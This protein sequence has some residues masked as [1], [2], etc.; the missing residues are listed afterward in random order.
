[1]RDRA[2]EVHLITAL[3]ME[4]SYQILALHKVANSSLQ[5][6]IISLV[7][8]MPVFP[9]VLLAERS[10]ASILDLALYHMVTNLLCWVI[11]RHRLL[12]ADSR[13]NCKQLAGNRLVLSSICNKLCLLELEGMDAAVV[14][15]CR[16]TVVSVHRLI[17]IH[18]FQLHAVSSLKYSRF[19]F[20]LKFY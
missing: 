16:E 6:T 5:S 8:A 7:E 2:I 20:F 15:G 4:V 3:A 1:M 12:M 14:I 18:V 10:E 17:S 9:M 13:S 19:F 11:R